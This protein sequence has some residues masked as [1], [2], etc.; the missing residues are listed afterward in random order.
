MMSSPRVH[1]HVHEWQPP[2]VVTLGD[3]KEAYRA[4]R[5]ISQD[6]RFEHATVYAFVF[7]DLGRVKIGISNDVEARLNAIEKQVRS[8]GNLFYSRA[9]NRRAEMAM[10]ERLSAWRI[11]TSEWFTDCD[12][13]RRAFT[14][15][16]E[17]VAK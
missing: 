16:A 5:P 15:Y 8:S 11:G 14:E 9:G 13:F 4:G 10:H 3:Q 17:E 2:R 12:D 6:F 1:V 7:P